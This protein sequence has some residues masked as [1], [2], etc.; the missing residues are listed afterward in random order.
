MP[1]MMTVFT[2]RKTKHTRRRK[3]EEEKT[4]YKIKFLETIERKNIN[5]LA[6]HT[7]DTSLLISRLKISLLSDIGYRFFSLL[8]NCCLHLSLSRDAGVCVCCY[9]CSFSFPIPDHDGDGD[10]DQAC[11]LMCEAKVASQSL[12]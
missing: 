5:I 9:E 11:C 6:A 1:R 2:K 8:I 7:D 12:M 4:L 10:Q 3:E